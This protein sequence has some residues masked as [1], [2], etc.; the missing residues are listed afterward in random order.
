[1]SSA[2]RMTFTP[3]VPRKEWLEFCKAAGI[4]Y[5][6]LTLGRNNF[7][8][9]ELGG[10][11]IH[12][13]DKEDDEKKNPV[14]TDEEKQIGVERVQYPWIHHPV[15]TD[16]YAPPEVA[17]EI[18]CQCTYMGGVLTNPDRGA[19]NKLLG[20]VRAIVALIK[21]RFGPVQTEYDEEL[22]PANMKKDEPKDGGQNPVS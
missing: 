12:F 4:K 11:E 13:G 1:M 9:P 7:Y 20:D 3:P 16:E 22:D 14:F 18:V 15:K 19:T 10:V 21:E 17:G 5:S 2:V 8:L 6:P